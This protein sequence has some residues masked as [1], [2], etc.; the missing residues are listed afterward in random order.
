MAGARCIALV[1]IGYLDRN[2][3][4]GDGDDFPSANFPLLLRISRL[5]SCR[6]APPLNVT[7]RER[8]EFPRV[9]RAPRSRRAT[10]SLRLFL[11]PPLPHFRIRV[12]RRVTVHL[13]YRGRER[14]ERTSRC[15]RYIISSR[16]SRRARRNSE[17]QAEASPRVYPATFSAVFRR[18]ASSR[19][20]T[21][22]RFTGLSMG[23]IIVLLKTTGNCGASLPR[24]NYRDAMSPA[25]AVYK[26]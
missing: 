21:I 5:V 14:N 1:A 3:S 2:P 25:A 6:L 12:F 19:S 13:K 4:P 9:A 10:L 17:L 24:G 26:F 16:D 7:S 23:I 11:R 15:R 18:R 22:S 8:R 20:R